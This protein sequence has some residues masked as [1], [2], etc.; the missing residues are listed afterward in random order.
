MI[1][2]YCH[3]D[4]SFKSDRRD[5]LII[6]LGFYINPKENGLRKLVQKFSRDQMVGSKVINIFARY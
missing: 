2:S 5:L 3:F 6:E 1:K 4:P